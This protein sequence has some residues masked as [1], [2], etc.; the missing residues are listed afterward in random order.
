MTSARD[1]EGKKKS[2]VTICYE[3]M[4]LL[5]FKA[6]NPFRIVDFA[7]L[8]ILTVEMRDFHRTGLPYPEEA[9]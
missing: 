6:A 5:T 1:W 9:S 7:S 2:G 8:P 4:G 3:G